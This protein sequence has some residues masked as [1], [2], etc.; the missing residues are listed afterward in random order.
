MREVTD[1]ALQQLYSA[2]RRRSYFP[3]EIP[4]ENSGSVTTTDILKGLGLL[5]PDFDEFELPEVIASTLPVH[6]GAEWALRP[7]HALQ[8]RSLEE[9]KE[10]ESLASS[11]SVFSSPPGS[12]EQA[13]TTHSHVSAS[14]PATPTDEIDMKQQ[15]LA[16]MPPSH[17][18]LLQGK[19]RQSTEHHGQRESYFQQAEDGVEPQ[20]IDLDAF[21][22]MSLCT[23]PTEISSSL[24]DNYPSLHHSMPLM[25]TP[26]FAQVQPSSLRQISCT[27]AI[28]HLGLAPL[29]LLQSLAT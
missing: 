18:P 4:N 17:Q 10:D 25:T 22:D 26:H 14:E 8:P 23:V 9:F 7:L 5:K 20:H 6:D 1:S 27:T 16:Y 13:P 15:F 24:S 19:K 21:L 11:R 29:P 12:D 2:C 28:Y 3:G